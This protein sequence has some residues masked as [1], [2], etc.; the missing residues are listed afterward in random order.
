MEA[1]SFEQCT[2]STQNQR[3]IERQIIQPVFPLTLAKANEVGRVDAE[4]FIYQRFE[5]QHGAKVSHFL[6]FIL[7]ANSTN[8]LVSAALGF[9]PASYSSHLFLEYYLDNDIQTTLSILTQTVVQRD[10][11]VEIGNLA[12][13]RQRATQTLFL[14][15]AELFY[16]AGYEWVV[17][18]AS[19]VVLQWLEKLSI[20]TIAIR[21]ADP[22]KLPDKGASWGSYYDDKPVVVASN[23]RQTIDRL[24]TNPMMQYLRQSYQHQISEFVGSLR[25]D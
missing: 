17:F 24:S 21:V 11:I 14:L 15:L 20:E 3:V 9:Q 22:A 13:G 23:T 25:H 7:S 10:D 16:Q 19:P 18:T 6:P 12:S 8:G 4:Q 5:K 2:N 1:R